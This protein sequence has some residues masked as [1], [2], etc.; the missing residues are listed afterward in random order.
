MLA[1]SCDGG[2]ADAWLFIFLLA[3]PAA[4]EDA[5]GEADA[6][7]PAEVDTENVGDESMLADVT[8]SEAP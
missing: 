4:E 8:M 7:A 2:L 1:F 3:T 5:K 6:D